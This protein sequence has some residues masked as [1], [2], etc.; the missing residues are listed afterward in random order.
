MNKF[1]RL[2]SMFA[3]AG[4]TFAYTSCTDYSEDINKVDNRVDN[5]EGR[6]TT[7]EGQV[8]NLETTTTQLKDAQAKTAAAVTT[9]E[10]TLKELQTKH[11][12]DIKDL[13]KAYADAD[14]AL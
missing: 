7:V 4:V 3:I 1:F 13:Q 9:L 2:V 8:K 6:L 14:A 10:T 12:K 5:V 11:D